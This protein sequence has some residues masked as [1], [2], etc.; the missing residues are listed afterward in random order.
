MCAL[1]V[2]DM[3]ISEVFL[4]HLLSMYLCWPPCTSNDCLAL[5]TAHMEAARHQ[6]MEIFYIT[7]EMLR[8]LSHLRNLL[9]STYSNSWVSQQQCWCSFLELEVF[10]DIYIHFVYTHAQFH[11]KT[12]PLLVLLC[13]II[14]RWTIFWNGLKIAYL[15]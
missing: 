2:S 3:I 13:F 6:S 10:L 11:K 15:F 4:M 9:M 1:I 14:S 8:L 5:K 7:Q 12:Y